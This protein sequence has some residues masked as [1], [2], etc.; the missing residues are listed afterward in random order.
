MRLSRYSP[1]AVII[2]YRGNYYLDL[3]IRDIYD[4][5]TVN[6]NSVYSEHGR[7]TLGIL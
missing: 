3:S 7:H 6:G 2:A 5:I 1:L 4:W